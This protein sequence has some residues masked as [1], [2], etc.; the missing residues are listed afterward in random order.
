MVPEALQPEQ[1]TLNFDGGPKTIISLPD[2]GVE[3]LATSVIHDKLW[4]YDKEGI[5]IDWH[6]DRQVVFDSISLAIQEGSKTRRVPLCVISSASMDGN[7]DKISSRFVDIVTGKLRK[8]GII[9]VIEEKGN[10][11]AKDWRK[12]LM[13]DVGLVDRSILVSDPDFL[14]WRGRLPKA[15]KKH[16]I[17]LIEVWKHSDEEWKH[18][19]LH[20]IASNV[21]ERF[22]REGLKV[23]GWDKITKYLHATTNPRAAIS[24]LEAGGG[25][26]LQSICGCEWET[27]LSG[28][29]H[30]VHVGCADHTS[31]SPYDNPLVQKSEQQDALAI[32][33]ATQKIPAEGKPYYIT[34]RPVELEQI[35]FDCGAHFVEQSYIEEELHNGR[36]R[37]FVQKTCPHDGLIE[38]RHLTVRRDQLSK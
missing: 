20:N 4:P 16:T 14:L 8:N 31:Q 29:M 33:N 7:S 5:F 26:R 30:N 19:R 13:H 22:A 25:V 21:K 2:K 27:N 23:I 37:I 9:Y 28:D 35:C 10:D 15:H 18:F 3:L 34:G 6:N 11:T 17:D 1:Y 12:E 36:V 24:F 38:T 32:R